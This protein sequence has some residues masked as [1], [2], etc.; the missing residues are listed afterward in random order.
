MVS[1]VCGAVQSEQICGE[2]A[3]QHFF[4][5]IPIGI[6]FDVDIE[7]IVVIVGGDSIA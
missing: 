6:S 3:E 7:S 2:S 5:A 1:A 4:G